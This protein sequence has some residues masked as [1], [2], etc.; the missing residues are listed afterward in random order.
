MAYTGAAQVRRARIFDGIFWL[1]LGLDSI[2]IGAGARVTESVSDPQQGLAWP[3]N[4]VNCKGLVM[5]RFE[6]L[7]S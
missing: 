4:W 1:Q 7:G 6:H 3:S 2:D 5:R